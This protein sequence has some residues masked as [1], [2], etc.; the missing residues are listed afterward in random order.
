METKS[1]R[2]RELELQQ[3]MATPEGRGQL[4]ELA[5]RY[6]DAGGRSRHEKASV[7]TYIIVHERQCGLIVG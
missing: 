1:L 5:N 7:I 2:T 3:M 6:R 4:Q